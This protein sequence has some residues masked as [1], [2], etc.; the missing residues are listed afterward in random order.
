M[1]QLSSAL[2]LSIVLAY[3]LYQTDG[4]IISMVLVNINKCLASRYPFG[5]KS[6]SFRTHI[7][8][9]GISGVIIYRKSRTLGGFNPVVQDSPG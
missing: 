5:Q 2:S 6:V 9:A 3:I 8:E 7:R 4:K 1:L